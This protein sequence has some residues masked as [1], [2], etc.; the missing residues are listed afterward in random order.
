MSQDKF[1]AANRMMVAPRE[2]VASLRSEGKSQDEIAT[3]FSR[4]F[5][6]S[7]EEAQRHAAG[8]PR[9]VESA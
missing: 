3:T 5:G 4:L 6:L 8:G 2:V 9:E 7:G 1:Q